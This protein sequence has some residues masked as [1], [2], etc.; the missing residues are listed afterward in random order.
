MGS[1]SVANGRKNY[2]RG[3]CT[4]PI[5]EMIVRFHPFG[6]GE[7]LDTVQ[8]LLQEVK[9][10]LQEVKHPLHDGREMSKEGHYDS[11]SQVAL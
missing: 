6:L 1:R 8:V 10:S 2:G 7:H 9:H 11:V 4:S 3:S 5:D